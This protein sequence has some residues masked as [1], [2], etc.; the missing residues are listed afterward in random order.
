MHDRMTSRR[1]V[2]RAGRGEDRAAIHAL[3]SRAF[4]RRQEAD[5]A[6]ALIDGPDETLSYVAEVEGNVVAHVLLSRL[7]EPDWALALAPLAVDPRWRDLALGTELVRH[8]TAEARAAGAFRAIFVLGR[9]DYYGRFGFRSEL[10]DGAEIPWQGPNFMAL[11][12][13]P[14]ALSGFRGPLRYPQAFSA[15]D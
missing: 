5:L 4:G 2:F 11:E 9:P 15:F 3:Q 10:A 7:A 8:G 12:L 1:T 6:I 14:G 13:E